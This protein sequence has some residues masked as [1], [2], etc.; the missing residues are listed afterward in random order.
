MDVPLYNGARPQLDSTPQPLQTPGVNLEANMQ[1]AQRGA[2]ALDAA[3]G[4]F[5]AIRDFGE[6]QR[7]EGI[8]GKTAADFEDEFT[9]RASLA[10]GS[11]DGLYDEEGHLHRGHLDALVKD[12]ANRVDEVRPGYLD[13]DSRLKAEAL[14][15]RTKQQFEIRA[16]GKAAEREIVVSRQ[17][18]QNNLKSALD[19]KDYGAARTLNRRAR[20]NDIISRNQYEYEDWKFN[21]LDRVEQFQ[22]GLKKNPLEVAAAFEDGLYDDIEPDTRRDLEKDLQ[23]ALR[24]QVRQ[25]PFTEEERK[26]ME[27]GAAVRPKFDRQPGDTEQ[28]VKWRE[29]KNRGMLHLHQKDIDA[30]WREDVYNAPVLKS[31]GQYHI[32]KNSL[33]RRWCDEKVGFGVNPELLGLA[34]D[35]RIADLQGLASARD[36]LNASEFFNTVDPADVAP[37]FYKKWDKAKGTWYWTD[38]GRKETEDATKKEYD[39]KVQQARSEAYAAYLFWS[40]NNPKADYYKQYQTACSLLADRASRLDEENEVKKED[41]EFKYMGR[42]LG[43]KG[44]EKGQKALEEQQK[45]NKEYRKKMAEGI[46]AAD[47]TKGEAVSPVLPAVMATDILPVPD[48]QPGAYLSREDYEKVV[49]FYG[50]APELVGVLPG[51]GSQR[52]CCRVP[53]LGWHEGDGVLLTR[54]ARHGQL[55]VVGRIDGLEVRFRRPKESKILSPEER[56]KWVEGK[57][58]KKEEPSLLPPLD[59]SASAPPED[60]GLLPVEGAGVETAVPVSESGLPP[61]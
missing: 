16:L 14:L 59:A 10:P 20:Q 38:A 7:I 37:E 54:G 18:Y 26:L 17:T 43:D 15:Q 44:R 25:I 21:Q 28:M 3:I 61:L 27:G 12:Y 24:Q 47:K 33:I 51:R 36:H 55:G 39:Q 32:W 11:E 9:R 2:Q 45:R 13:P 53:V 5:K 48:A 41:L 23:T 57:G 46:A 6:D 22:E 50:D 52:A 1:A 19:R 4:K 40:Q 31:A 8:L 60:Y 49:E 35:E 42:D 34:A 29:A 58:R 56:R 30:A